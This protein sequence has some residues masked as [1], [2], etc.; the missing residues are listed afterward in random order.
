MDLHSER[1]APMN[2]A[3]E[4]EPEIVYG[5]EEAAPN[6]PNSSNSTNN[7][8]NSNLHTKRELA[9]AAIAGGVAGLLL[10]GPVVGV[11][12]AGG[13]ALAVT[14]KGQTGKAARAGGEA[15]ASLGDRIKKIDKKHKVVHK[16]GKGIEKGAKWMARKLKPRD[17]Q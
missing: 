8:N 7:S 16:T 17:A 9:G 11:V 12:A 3:Y 2:P 4:E 5:V 10:V 6:S 13:A 14:N 15:V 1:P